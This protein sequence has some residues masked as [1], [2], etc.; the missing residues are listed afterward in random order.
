MQK[1][2][3]VV[4]LFSSPVFNTDIEPIPENVL[5]FMSEI[6]Y[7]RMFIG[8]GWYS[9]DK[10]VL[11]KSELSWLKTQIMDALNIYVRNVLCVTDNIT[12]EM[13]NSWVVKHDKGDWGQSHIHTN[14]VLSGVVYLDVDEKSGDIV[15]NR[16]TIQQNLFP[17]A[18]DIE[19]SEWNVFNS[20][21]W[22]FQPHNNQVFFFP[23]SL[24][25][26]IEP[27]ESENIRTS[28]AFNF[29]PKGKLGAKEFELELK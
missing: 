12:F 20:R 9:Y 10:Y 3:N 15:F 6:P 25:H 19:F 11:N 8:N 2:Y 16:D 23:S 13:T 27:N 29:F 7:E 21:K 4:P 18:I 17:N 24:L 5:K 14:C 1:E 28:L 22:R 26:S